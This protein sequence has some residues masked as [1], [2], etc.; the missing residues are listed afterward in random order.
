ML[1]ICAPDSARLR[2]TLDEIFR[3]RLTTDYTFQD[4]DQTG[5]ISI[6]LEGTLLLKQICHPILWQEKLISWEDFKKHYD[7]FDELD[8]FSRVFI[9]LSRYEEYVNPKKDQWDR[10]CFKDSLFQ[11]DLKIP[12]VEKWVKDIQES[13]QKN[14]DRKIGQFSR[15]E[16]EFTVDIDVAYSVRGKSKTIFWGGV[17]KSFFKGNINDCKQKLGIRKGKLPDPYDAYTYLEEK[18]SDQKSR[19]FFLLGDRGNMDKNLPYNSPELIALI[20]RLNKFNT[21]GIH[22]SFASFQRP[23]KVLLEI[24]RLEKVLPFK[25]VENRFH[26]LRFNLPDSYQQLSELGIQRDHSMGFADMVGFRAGT[27][28]P[29]NF[30]NLHTNEKKMLEIHPITYMDGTLKE[31]M[32]MSAEKAMETLNK[33]KVNCNET[34][35]KMTGLWH[36]DTLAESGNWK[37]WRKVFEKQLSFSS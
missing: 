4:T 5:E 9:F 14:T 3:R 29:F 12:Y 2:F 25:V 32:G 19:V 23:E 37:G 20:E 10:F 18:L 26:Y 16:Q 22:P 28:Y 7:H 17:F 8:S 34:G 35:G 21:V 27:A 11:W 6:F 13:I 33:I 36:N 31:Y 15:L 30:F 24:K 1:T